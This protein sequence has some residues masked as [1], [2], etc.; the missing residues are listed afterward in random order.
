[1]RPSLVNTFPSVQLGADTVPACD[2]VQLLV[3]II[4]ADLSL[5]RQVSVVSSAS[6]YWLWQLRRVHWSLDNK[7]AAILV[8]AFVTSRVDCCNLLLAG[9]PDKLQLV[10]NAAEVQPRLDT[11]TSLWAALAKCSRSSHIQAWGDS[12]QMLAWPGIGL[13]VWTVHTG[14]SSCWMTASSF[15]QPPSSRCSTV[16][17]RYVWPSHLR[18]RWTND[19][20]LVLKQFAWA[21]HANW[22]FSSYIED[23]SFWTVFRTLSALEALFFAMMHYINWHLHHITHSAPGLKLCKGRST[24]HGCTE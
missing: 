5:D 19:M 14:R 20:E 18:C 13:S 9:A 15:R 7:S 16:S 10:T 17:A 4:S 21:G 24:K 6:F 23:V 2:H 1:M 8:H 22:L 12:V 11:P 3:V